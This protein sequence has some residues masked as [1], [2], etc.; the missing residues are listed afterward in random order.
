MPEPSSRPRVPK[1]FP[2][3][4]AAV[5]RAQNHFT[6]KAANMAAVHQ[7]N[8]WTETQR[9]T[10]AVRSIQSGRH[11]SLAS[12]E[13][14]NYS[15]TED[16]STCPGGYVPV[17]GTSCFPC[18]NGTFPSPD[19]NNEICVSCVTGSVAIPGSPLCT[20][21]EA[22]FEPNEDKSLCIPCP[23]ALLAGMQGGGCQN[24]KEVQ[25]FLQLG[26]LQP[27]HIHFHS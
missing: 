4:A 26:E 6:G 11:V 16:C 19:H 23:S 3:R 12:Q 14:L 17:N 22:G 13:N 8:A 1:Q 2:Q 25:K 10:I 5:A 21:C 24:D 9:S 15:G 20:A 27:C 18:E 7:D